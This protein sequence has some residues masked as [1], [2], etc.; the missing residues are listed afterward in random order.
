MIKYILVITP[1]YPIEGDPV[2]PFVKNLCDEFAQSGLS[3]TVLSP[4]SVTSSLLHH[5]KLR[6]VV[7]KE[8]VE[9]STITIYQPYSITPLHKHLR[10]FNYFI[11]YSA[12]RF[13]RKNK[14]CAD[15]CYCHFWC[16]AYWVMP[17]MKKH[18]IPV[19][20][21]SGESQISTLLSEKEQYPDF[22]DYVKGVVCVSGKNRDES[23]ALGYTSID[24]CAVIPNAVNAALFYKRNKAEC[25][26]YLGFPQ[27]AFIVAFVGWFIERKGPLR[28][29]EAINRIGEVKSIFVGSGEQ[30]PSCDGVLFKGSLPHEQVPL[31]LGAADC[32]VLP[33][34]HEGCCNAVIEAMACGL[35]VISSNL[36]FNWDVL[37]GTNSIMIDPTNVDQIAEAIRE[38]RDNQ[39]LCES[40]AEGAIKK[41]EILTIE[42][43]ADAI[44]NFMSY[45]IDKQ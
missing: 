39:K 35:P 20:V 9:G 40:L 31:Y 5:K 10:I 26:S 14:I 6:P 23:V 19:F 16:S 12:L 22:N 34:L 45:R 43:R 44:L 30:E 24:K 7:R 1:N 18:N 42:K 13:L 33:T 41:A 11:R 28:V 21:A 2:Y 8:I 17:Y 29:V 36:P 38:L 15:V 4:Q 3:I 37:D 27:D 25:R 32:F